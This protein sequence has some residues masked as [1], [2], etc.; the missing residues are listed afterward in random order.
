MRV[1]AIGAGLMGA[2]IGCE[3]AL[4]GHDVTFV[5]RRPGAARARVDAAF[6][7]A[8]RYALAPREVIASARR[9]VALIADLAAIDPATELV[10]E[11]VVENLDEKGAVLRVAAAAAP[12]AIVATNT[13]SISIGVIGDAC[14]APERVVGTHYWNPPL[15]IPLVEVIPGT[16]T[17]PDVVERVVDTLT[18][19][20]K[21]PVRAER[22]VTGFIWNRL[23]LALLREAVWLTEAG[24]ADPATI[25]RIVRE[26]LA[27]RWRYTGPFETAALGGADTFER[28]AAYIWPELSTA[29]E[30]HDLAKWLPADAEALAET[31]ER[32]D[33]GLLRDLHEEQA[34]REM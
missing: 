13:S 34:E 16:R 15:L 23:Q 2:H 32:R 10:I 22:D 4:G 26:G 7:L 1:A 19:L 28:I 33:R 27:R 24:V 21:R 5:A 11:S 14:G 25:D 12:E 20:G 3:Y 17:R 8:E 30:L 29:T 6:D 9:R 31:R 18:A